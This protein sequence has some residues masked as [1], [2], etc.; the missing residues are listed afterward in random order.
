MA[1]SLSRPPLQSAKAEQL[2]VVFVGITWPPETF[3]ERLIRGLL[4]AGVGITVACESKPS[5][6]WLSHPQLRWLYAPTWHGSTTSRLVRTARMRIRSF[7]GESSHVRLFGSHARQAVSWRKRIQS[8]HRLLP[9]VG[10]RADVIYFPWNSAAISYLPLFGLGMPVILSCRGSQVNVT[11]LNPERSQLRDGLTRTFQKAK[12]VHC[13]S[14]AIRDEATH[15]GLDPN[16]AAV[17][18][19]AVDLMFFR[20]AAQVAPGNTFRITTT[21]GLHWRKGYEY[22]LL[23]ISNLANRGVKV[24]FDIVGDGPERERLLYC[25]SDLNLEKIV[26]LH[27]PKTPEGVRELLHSSDVFLLSSLSEGISNAVLEAMACAVPVVTTDCGG[28]GE[29]VTDG[30]EGF[31]TPVRDVDAITEALTRLFE[32]PALRR[33]MGNA[34]RERVQE[35]F[36]LSGQ[37]DQF[38]SLCERTAR[39]G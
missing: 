20:P 6:S 5:A 3:I 30:V 28:M 11:P 33:R 16:K 10:L 22:A 35:A 7:A 29:V 4:D 1:R 2:R 26:R 21:G 34:G 39:V 12:A 27:G 32:D 17:I 19:P 23:A 37:V 24:Q 18:P 8:W 36:S 25:I 38:L 9:F 13:V 15:Y 14:Q 31:V